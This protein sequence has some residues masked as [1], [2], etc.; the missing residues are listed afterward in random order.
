MRWLAALVILAGCDAAAPP[1]P[2]PAPPSPGPPA[3]SGVG[4]IAGVVRVKGE[5]VAPVLRRATGSE[6]HCGEAPLDIGAWRVD[7][8][9]RAL[10]DG[11]V[12]VE[13]PSGEWPARPVPVL[14]NAKCLFQPPVILMAPGDLKI[15]NSDTVAH[16]AD[17]KS[18]INPPENHLL[19][20]GSHKLVS[21]R[22]PET[23]AVGCS[24][25]PWMHAVVIVTRNPFT[26]LTDGEGCFEIR[27]VPAGRHRVVFWH[28]CVGEV[29]VGEVE[30]KA[31]EVARLELEVAPRPGF[32]EVTTTLPK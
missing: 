21:L 31:G 17:V 7:P 6:H 30:V 5:E 22:I 10:R 23:V 16:S 1:P 13:G 26:A 28:R 19:A 20:P 8:A 12:R 9:T 25:H 2:A 29:G 32:R 11:F 27:G 14:D 3:P 15:T 4:A 18:K 24:V